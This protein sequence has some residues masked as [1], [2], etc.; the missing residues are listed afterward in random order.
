MVS[1]SSF[2]DS[3]VDYNNNS[4]ESAEYFDEDLKQA[5]AEVTTGSPT[6]VTRPSQSRRCV[7]HIARSN[8][9]TKDDSVLLLQNS[10]FVSVLL[11]KLHKKFGVL[12]LSLRTL[13]HII[14]S[15]LKSGSWKKFIQVRLNRPLRTPAELYVN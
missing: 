1:Q 11:H 14:K 13:V 12:N 8:I 5:V 3:V 7:K 9:L 15:L 10:S 6:I 4:Y 2:C